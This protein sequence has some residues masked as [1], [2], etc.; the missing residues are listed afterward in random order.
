MFTLNASF[1]KSGE[2]K[3]ISEKMT[4]IE[5]YCKYQDGDREKLAKFQSSRDIARDIV[6]K[7]KEG[8]SIEVSFSINGRTYKNKEGKDCYIQN[9]DA[10]IVKNSS[11]SVAKNATAPQ[12]TPPVEDLPF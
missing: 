6:K 7:S 5:F 3:V 2:E 10:Y 12:S 4:V 11:A 1:L 8:D 9:L